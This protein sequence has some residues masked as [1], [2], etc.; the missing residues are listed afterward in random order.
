MKELSFIW[1]PIQYQSFCL[2]STSEKVGIISLIFQMKKLRI[3]GIK[4]L[5]T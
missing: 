1:E 2:Y 5:W 4:W 3:F